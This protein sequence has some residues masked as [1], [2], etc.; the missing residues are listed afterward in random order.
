MHAE[1]EFQVNVKAAKGKGAARQ[2]RAAGLVPG[3]VYGYQYEP[4]MVTFEER[5]LVKALSTPAGRNIFLRLKSDDAEIDGIRVLIRD[6]QVHPLKRRFI[7]ADFFKL[8][9]DREISSTIPFRMVGDAI[10]VT[11]G[12]VLQIA[13]HE[14]PVVCKPDDLL[15]S[16]DIDITDLDVGDSIHVED[17]EVPEG[18][19]FTISPK[20]TICAV[21][22]PAA[23]EEEEVEEE[24]LLEGEEGEEE[25]EGEEGEEGKGEKS[26]E[27]E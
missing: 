13:R 26:T 4:K 17:I 10:G 1:V 23:E 19:T 8:D 5:H 7:H 25:G 15:S 11:L 6:F 20:L 9:S 3:V 2:T 24:E 22:V 21:V 27:K 18:V 16:I 12:G 14:I